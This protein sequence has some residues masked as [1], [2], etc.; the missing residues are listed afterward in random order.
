MP[1]CTQCGKEVS[2]ADS[3]CATCGAGQGAAPPPPA[4]P[5]A[6]AADG[7]SEMFRNLA[8]QR[9]AMLCYI[10]W[11]GWIVS[12]VVLAADRFR[13]E[14]EARFHAFQGLYLFVVWLFVDQV[15][16]PF[17]KEIDPLRFVARLLHAAV[18]GTWIF[19]LVKT[20]HGH[21]VRLPLLGELADRSVSEQ[22]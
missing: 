22:K 6:A 9:A 19:M 18:L 11:L 5:A 10:P 20:G 17:I 1:Y 4:A 21:T 8:P 12:I 7:R 13:A 14:R 3:F 16:E 15:F 2:P